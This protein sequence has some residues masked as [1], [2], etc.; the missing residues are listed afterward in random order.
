MRSDAHV[1]WRRRGRAVRGCNASRGRAGLVDF[2]DIAP[3]AGGA[4][5]RVPVGAVHARKPCVMF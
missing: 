3:S 1:D 4:G 5:A 2:T